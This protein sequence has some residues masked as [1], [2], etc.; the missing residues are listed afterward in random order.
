MPNTQLLNVSG[1]T[2]K[3]TTGGT[4]VAT[5]PSG[6][7][8]GVTLDG[9]YSVEVADSVVFTSVITNAPHWHGDTNWSA[10]WRTA[11]D[12]PYYVWTHTN[13]SYLWHTTAQAQDGT[14]GNYYSSFT[15]P[16][17][18]SMS[19]SNN[20]NYG[21][22]LEFSETY[23]TN[24]STNASGTVLGTFTTTSMLK[25][26]SVHPQSISVQTYAEESGWVAMGFGF[27]LTVFVFLYIKR[28]LR[29]IPSQGGD[30]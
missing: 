3:V 5:V 11:Q 14:L 7:Q 27:G 6:F 19:L 4:T 8:G 16:V 12:A 25:S 28:L 1:G 26:V 23:S 29:A 21:G 24:Q 30:F 13:G 9:S 10:G 17:P 18:Y 22:L 20:W 15:P 2:V